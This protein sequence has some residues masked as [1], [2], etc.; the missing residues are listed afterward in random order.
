MIFRILSSKESKRFTLICFAILILISLLYFNSLRNNF[1][2]W[3]DPGLILQNK[4]IRSLEW[5]NIREIFTLRKST[6]YQPIR[7]LSYAIDYHFWK[8][9][10]VGYRITNI[11]FYILTSIMVYLTLL[12]LSKHLREKASAGFARA[13]RHFRSASLCCTSCSRRG[14]HLASARKEVLQ[15]FFFFLAFYAYLRGREEEGLQKDLLSRSCL[16]FLSFLPFYPN[17]V[18]WFF[19]E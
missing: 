13:G 12:H 18:P 7:V 16:C 15:G 8:L 17:P 5:D 14:R 2:N 11:L 1:V 6:T 3:D 10:P 4:K 9:N 19:R